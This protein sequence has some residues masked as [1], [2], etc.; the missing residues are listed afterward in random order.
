[1]KNLPRH[2]IIRFLFIAS[3]VLLI[4]G[5]SDFSGTVR[6]I[7]YPPDF[8]IV[9][10]DELRSSMHQLAFQL[11]LLDKALIEESGQVSGQQQQVLDALGSIEAIGSGLQAGDAGSNHPSLQVYMNNFVNDVSQARSAAAMDPPRYYLA[12]RVSGGCVSCH[13]ANR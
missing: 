13:R 5:C 6:Q 11:Q 12:G 1:M 2:N 8:K 9:S 10:P 4:Y 7:T 3:S